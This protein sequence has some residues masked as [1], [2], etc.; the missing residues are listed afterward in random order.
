VTARERYAAVTFA[1]ERDDS[2]TLGD[3]TR[4]E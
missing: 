4:R 3:R 1:P 2:G